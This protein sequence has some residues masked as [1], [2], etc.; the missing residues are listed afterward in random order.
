MTVVSVEAV[1]E[2][3]LKEACSLP[4]Q[5]G[6]A[7]YWLKITIWRIG[8]KDFDKPLTFR[9]AGVAVGIDFRGEVVDPG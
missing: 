9:I 8:C 2:D 1:V 4:R 6:V 5:D 7:V 3:M